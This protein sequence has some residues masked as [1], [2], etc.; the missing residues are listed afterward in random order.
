MEQI[1]IVA[2]V[3]KDVFDVFI[4]QTLLAQE[5]TSL[6]AISK[7]H[8]DFS[9]EF[10]ENVVVGEAIGVDLKVNLPNEPI[11]LDGRNV[12]NALSES[13]GPT[14]LSTHSGGNDPVGIDGF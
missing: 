14:L 2:V 1:I 8:F 3:V 9:V 10:H 13:M 6:G 7:A 4:A 12:P 5:D 11:F